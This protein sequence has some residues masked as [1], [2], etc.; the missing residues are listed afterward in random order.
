M[1]T[2]L[3]TGRCSLRKCIQGDIDLQMARVEVK[4]FV[5]NTDAREHM[6]VFVNIENFVYVRLRHF[7]HLASSAESGQIRLGP[8]FQPDFQIPLFQ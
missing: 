1:D 7:L 8:N 2:E 3:Q 5:V 6:E 4:S